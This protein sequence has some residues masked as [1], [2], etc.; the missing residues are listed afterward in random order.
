MSKLEN[1]LRMLNI[2]SAR[3]VV[4][5]TELSESLDITV[6]SV[7]RLKEDLEMSGYTIDTIMGPGGGYKLRSNA[8]LQPVSFSMEE[9]K[10]LKKALAILLHQHGSSFGKNFVSTVSKLSA[11]LS[12]QP[13]ESSMAFQSIKLN[14]NPTV[15][16]QIL[17][18]LE[19]SIDKKNKI[20]I[21]YKKNHSTINEYIFEP[22][23][24]ILVNQIWY[25]Y[26]YDQKMRYI[27]LKV[28][29]IKSVEVTDKTFLKDSNRQSYAN[30]S[31]YGYRIDPVPAILVIK[32]LDY[33][34]E[35]IWGKNQ[36]I[37]WIDDSSFELSVEFPNE[38][39][40]K[41][42]ILRAGPNVIVIEPQ[43]M[44]DFVIK[45]Y[46]EALKLYD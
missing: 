15:Y 32:N 16:N 1:A 44:K 29:R 24:L 26:G 19:Y 27:S 40:L 25:L 31:E 18:T 28:N 45:S 2:L 41:D 17:E 39:A 20:K 36:E 23:D 3:S 10:E 12:H 13:I 21:K 4:S 6:R 9:K 14:V 46:R 7:Q 5:L 11:Q 22:Y 38:L 33:I 37:N 34:S 30:L 8:Q 42:F 43:S 35:Y